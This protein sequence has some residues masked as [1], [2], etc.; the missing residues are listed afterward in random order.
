MPANSPNERTKH[1]E[2]E[3]DLNV[4][5]WLF[6]EGLEVARACFEDDE[7]HR[8]VPSDTNKA[9]FDALFGPD[10]MHMIYITGK[11][12]Q[13]KILLQ[14]SQF[15]PY[16]LAILKRISSRAPCD[17]S[18][19]RGS[20]QYEIKN[21]TAYPWAYG[22]KWSQETVERFLAMQMAYRIK[23]HMGA[24]LVD[25][26]YAWKTPELRSICLMI[27]SAQHVNEIPKESG[28][29]VH[30]IKK[31]YGVRHAN[32]RRDPHP[33]DEIELVLD[34]SDEEE[35]EEEADEE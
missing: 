14:D 27:Q 15:A 4:P 13:L 28:H 24:V 26:N 25:V 7:V 11:M 30:S 18:I 34:S 10:C 9:Y 12:P 35:E 19:S 21:P 31:F 5:E 32:L 33:Q 3:A 1:M 16:K 17:L 2:E 20:L 23:N 8:R 22:C 6:P 29:H